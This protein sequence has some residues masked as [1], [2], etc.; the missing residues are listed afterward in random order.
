MAIG[1]MHGGG[2]SGNRQFT[3]PVLVPVLIA[4]TLGLGLLS[5]VVASGDLEHVLKES[6][7]TTLKD[8]LHQKRT[9]VI[10]ERSVYPED[11]NA[12][13][14]REA[15]KLYPPH[16]IIATPE[17][18]PYP[19]E[20]VLMYYPG[21]IGNTT[22]G[23]TGLFSTV[24]ANT[25]PKGHYTIGGHLDYYRITKTYGEKINFSSDE[26]ALIRRFPFTATLG[27]V[28]G[29]EIGMV[30]PIVSWRVRTLALEPSNAQQTGVGD[31]ELKAKYRVPLGDG[32]QGAAIGFGVKF[33]SGDDETLGLVGATGAP[34]MEIQGAIS[35]QFG[36]INSHLNMGYV[37]TG[38]PSQRP[39]NPYQP[40]PNRSFFNIGFDYSRNEDVMLTLEI[41]GENEDGSKVEF[42]PGIRSRIDDEMLL[43]FA[44]PVCLYNTQY[45]GYQFRMIFGAAYTF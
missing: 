7:Y 20:E 8:F 35:S 25:V 23:L 24:T 42:I 4:V 19:T 31:I 5:P 30:V 43:D 29:F 15:D 12:L 10:R 40:N 9:G 34:D 44:M 26:D 16:V 27:V 28:D 38:D 33:P 6:G 21:I 45:L 22:S 14:P 41:S 18:A 17:D 39:G 32:S 3:V 1:T 11:G 37:F 2:M 36:L 13:A